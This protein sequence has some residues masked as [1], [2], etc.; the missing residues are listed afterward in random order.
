MTGQRAGWGKALFSSIAVKI[1]V[2]L[3]TFTVHHSLWREDNLS[4]WIAEQLSLQLSQ[5]S[6]ELFLSTYARTLQ[7]TAETMDSSGR[8][9]TYNCINTEIAQFNSRVDTAV[10]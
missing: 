4:L 6:R 2:D 9:S 3:I 10:V 5:R 7:K 8:S 1:W